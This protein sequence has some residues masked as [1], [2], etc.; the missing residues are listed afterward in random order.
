LDV[1]AS[2]R[3]HRFLEESQEVITVTGR[4]ALT[5]ALSTW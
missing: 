3:F 2:M 5:E 4:F 1:P